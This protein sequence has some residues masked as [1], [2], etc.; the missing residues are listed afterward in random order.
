MQSLH[1][2]NGDTIRA[3]LAAKDG[4]VESDAKDGRP[5][6]RVIEDLYLSS[7]SRY[8]TDGELSKLLATIGD[9]QENNR[10]VAIEDLYW[11]VL[12]S[13]EFLFNH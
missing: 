11:A 3:K 9:V 12:S 4:K 5:L 7:L 13:R 10:R 2:S 1:I 8:P 6:Y